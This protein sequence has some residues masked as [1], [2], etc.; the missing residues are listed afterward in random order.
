MI[1]EGIGKGSKVKLSQK[2]HAVVND[3]N[4]AIMDDLSRFIK[5]KRRLNP[6]ITRCL[7]RTYPKE[8][9]MVWMKEVSQKLHVVVNNEA[10]AVIDE[11]I[12]NSEEEAEFHHQ[13]FVNL[14]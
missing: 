6:I 7:D 12:C 10:N 13:N 3:E 1:L 4:N 9:I 5:E 14:K 2:L 8:A 11:S